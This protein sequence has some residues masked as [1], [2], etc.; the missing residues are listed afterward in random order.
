L[1][2]QADGPNGPQFLTGQQ[3]ARL[4]HQAMHPCYGWSAGRT[5]MPDIGGNSME[6]VHGHDAEPELSVSLPFS[7]D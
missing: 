7:A 3:E 5:L 4:T 2:H 1:R 6:I